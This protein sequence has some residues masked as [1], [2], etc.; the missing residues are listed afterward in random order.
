MTVAPASEANVELALG[1][2]ALAGGNQQLAIAHADRVIQLAPMSPAGYELRAYVTDGSDDGDA[3][4]AALERAIELGSRDACLYEAK[5]Y[6]LIA[7]DQRENSFMD[8]LLSADVAR[9]AADLYQRALGLRPSGETAVPGLVVALWNVEAFTDADE[10]SLNASRVSFP[11]SGLLLVGQAALEK[12]RRNIQE[13]TRLLHQA[14]VEPYTLPRE[15]RRAVVALRANWLG[16][17]VVEQLNT[18]VGGARFDEARALLGEQ[19]ADTTIPAPLR[20]MMEATQRDLP[21]MERLHG[22][23]QAVQQGR[24]DEGV[25]VLTG[26]A[27]NPHT[28]DRTRR[29]AD[30]LLRDIGARTQQE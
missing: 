1:R 18:L 20:T 10:V 27:E 25:A 14:T 9:A 17:W 7:A 21:D 19:L 29:M 8:E 6:R 24:R 11:T 12:N 4:D 30:R 22:A 3:S 23:L 28:A 13:A 26:L 15:H 2:V 16:E 5:A